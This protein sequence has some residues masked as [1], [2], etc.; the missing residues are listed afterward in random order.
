MVHFWKDKLYDVSVCN[1]CRHFFGTT[2]F[3]EEH[4]KTLPNGFFVCPEFDFVR[5]HKRIAEILSEQNH[6]EGSL[7]GKE[8]MKVY[9]PYGYDPHDGMWIYG[10]FDTQEKVEKRLNQIKEDAQIPFY[11]S[12]YGIHEVILNQ[13][14]TISGNMIEEEKDDSLEGRGQ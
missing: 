3:C 2:R 1:N 14:C 12:V 10:I 11:L 7:E 13:N 8:V 9:V 6:K 4:Q 5:N